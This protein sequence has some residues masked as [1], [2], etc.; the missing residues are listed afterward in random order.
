MWIWKKLRNKKGFTLIELIVTF[1]LIGI[2]MVSATAVMSSFMHVF[3]RV[4]SISSAQNVADVL[5]T[6]AAGE[7]SGGQGGVFSP[8][9]D[10]EEKIGEE[11]SLYIYQSQTYGGSRHDIAVFRNEEGIQVTM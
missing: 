11:Y 2:F 8:E 3:A 1:V 10:E 7:L 4:K 5:L 6:K 9:K